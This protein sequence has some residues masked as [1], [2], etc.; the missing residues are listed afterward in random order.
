MRIGII[1]IGW[2]EINKDTLTSQA[3]GGSET[4]LLSVTKEL[5]KQGHDVTVFCDTKEEWIDGARYVPLY[6]MIDKFI[7]E[8]NNPYNFIILNRII[9]RFNTDIITAIRQYNATQN[10]FIQMHDLSLLYEDHIATSR[11]LN[12]T[13]IFDKRVR[14]IIF[15]TEWHRDNF[16]LQYPNLNDIPK[17]VIPNGVDIS[18]I[19]KKKSK[20]DNRILW[21]SCA[22]RGL[23]I[24]IS[25]YDEIKAQV[26]DFGIDV[27]GYND[28]SHLNTQGKDIHILGNLPKE[29]LYEEMNKHKVWFYPG[30]FAET[31]CITMVE[32]MLC[33]NFVISPFTYGTHDIL[34]DELR[35]RFSMTA[36]FSESEWKETAKREAI[37]Y[38]V[39]VLTNKY[40][41]VGEPELIKDITNQC[42]QECLRYTWAKTAQRYINT[43][44]H[45]YMLDIPEMR[46]HLKGVFLAQ[47]CNLPFFKK[48]LTMVEHTWARDLIDGKYPGYKFFG[49]TSCDGLHPEPCI[50]GNTI[51]VR[52]DDKIEGTYNKMRDAYKLL[53][54]HYD[55]DIMFRTNTSNFINVEL[56]IQRMEKLRENEVVSDICG[57]Y[58]LMPNN[59]I[60]FQ[61][62]TFVGS[63]YIMSRKIADSI[64]LSR[65]DNSISNSNDGDDIVACYILN[66]LHHP[67]SIILSDLVL[68]PNNDSRMTYRYKCTNHPEEVSDMIASIDEL[69]KKRYTE[70]PNVV[71]SQISVSYRMLHLDPDKREEEG[72]IQHLLELNEAYIRK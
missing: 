9:R 17:Y 50:D 11:E 39:A 8:Q 59:S 30:T 3:L 7:A 2:K 27:A 65:Y 70:D 53:L 13:G 41:R 19:P 32:N 28:L 67:G 56:A 47:S 12:G 29:K 1:D 6:H 15:L 35:N 38:I 36:N 31:F 72:E 25:M 37:N 4:W 54:A 18:L 43:Y 51:Y 46:E 44:R 62:N 26:P 16:A 24:L 10:I 71:N 52:N 23:D 63:A 69:N 34:S 45:I 20:T 42:Y 49:F 14:G 48:E 33:K 58:H 55:F 64:F 40:E 61:F 60:L 57:Y 5:V 66:E 21:S 22:E 68:N